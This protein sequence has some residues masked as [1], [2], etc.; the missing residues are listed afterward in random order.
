MTAV[1]DRP[2]ELTQ[3]N[4]FSDA[5]S[6]TVW[7]GSPDIA[8]TPAFWAKVTRLSDEN[9]FETHR[10]TDSLASECVMCL[11]GGHGIPAEHG[12]AAFHA[13][14]E[15]GLLNAFEPPPLAAITKVLEE[16]IGLPS[17]HAIK[18]R[19]AK[20]KSRYIANFL[21]S[22]EE[23]HDLDHW[24]NVAIRDWLVGF[25][26]IGLK[27]ASW[28]VRNWFD[29]DDVAILDIHVIRAGVL[30]GFFDREDTLPRD[31]RKM[32]EKYLSF[33]KAIGVR[34]SLLDAVIWDQMRRAGRLAVRLFQSH[35]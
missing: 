18:Y 10:L 3:H 22:F 1:I 8:F 14:S 2:A 23:P 13:L 28:I 25:D 29:A 6:D 26:G 9:A 17:G 24:E 27:T 11:L 35:L 15:A 12:I 16:P 7:W 30:A 20:Q 4:E 34:P 33:A 31:Y 32:E 19:F 21:H 5:E